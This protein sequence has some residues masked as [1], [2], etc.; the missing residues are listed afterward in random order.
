MQKLEPLCVGNVNGA[1]A[2]E[3][4][5]PQKVKYWITA[6][7]SDSSLGTYPTDLKAG[8]QSDIYEHLQRPQMETIQVSVNRRMD[9]ENVA[10]WHLEPQKGRTFW[11]RTTWMNLANTVLSETSQMQKHRNCVVPLL[12]GAENKPV[13]KDR[14][15]KRASRGWARAGGPVFNEHPISGGVLEESW[16]RWW[17][18]PCPT[19]RMHLMPWPAHLGMV[20]MLNFVFHTF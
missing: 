7:P 9:K 5:F 13:H 8:T 11:P 14:K 4:R 12:W 16:R 10:R 6:E 3:N 20:K 1:A 2:V 19:V 15:Y 18:G 17:W